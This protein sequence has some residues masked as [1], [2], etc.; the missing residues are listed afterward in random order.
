M[1]SSPRPQD[2]Q[3]VAPQP[4]CLIIPQLEP[5]H[6]SS[7]AATFSEFAAAHTLAQ[8]SSSA[9]SS[10]G[11]SIVL[12]TAPTS[13]LQAPRDASVSLS[14]A[15]MPSV[16]ASAPSEQATATTTATASA[17]SARAGTNTNSASGTRRKRRRPPKS[18]VVLIAEAIL[19]SPMK[20]LS[21]REI[22]AAIAAAYP[23]H[24][25]DPVDLG[26]QNTVRYNLS[27][28][29]AFV[30]VPHPPKYVGPTTSNRSSFWTI[31]QEF[32]AQFERGNFVSAESLDP[33]GYPG[34]ASS[35]AAPVTAAKDQAGADATRQDAPSPRR[36]RTVSL[37]H[38][39]AVPLPM[40]LSPVASPHTPI[41]APV[42]TISALAQPPASLVQQQK[43]Q[44]HHHHPYAVPTPLPPMSVDHHYQHLGSL[45]TPTLS[46]SMHTFAGSSSSSV[47]FPLRSPN[48]LSS[49]GFHGG[50]QSHHYPHP[51]HIVSPLLMPS[52]AASA[53]T[54]D[55]Q[56]RSAT[57]E[58]SPVG[59]VAPAH[60]EPSSPMSSP[61]SSHGGSVHK[62][63]LSFLMSA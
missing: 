55:R 1:S 26:W 58:L 17:S 39:P 23:T 36:Q 37:C 9:S 30:K 45:P 41:L 4:N 52:P 38:K 47:F 16:T 40:P 43:Q 49:S 14:P 63:S 33:A 2:H 22:Y 7:A 51:H 29:P 10:S 5:Y 32:L 42:K 24:Y 57:R 8:L 50:Q 3:Q 35:A 56:G 19:N 12:P 21:I 53:T 61:S 46:P 6:A 15:P 11:P 34:H 31:S 28:H 18:Y 13:H 59:V 25:A 44:R 62:M 54:T 60:D 20:C 48:A 27:R